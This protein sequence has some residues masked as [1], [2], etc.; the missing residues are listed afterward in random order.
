MVNLYLIVT[1]YWPFNH[2]GSM[3]SPLKHIEASR[4]AEHETLESISV[5][6]QYNSISCLPG[7]KYPGSSKLNPADFSENI[8]N[9]FC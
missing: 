3:T 9:Q 5:T 8:S 4:K 6:W 1:F 2:E 7:H